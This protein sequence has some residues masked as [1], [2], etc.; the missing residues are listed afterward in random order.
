M[1]CGN[2]KTAVGHVNLHAV[3]ARQAEPAS[4]L[5]RRHL[6]HAS[7]PKMWCGA[8]RDRAPA[9]GMLQRVVQKI[10]RGLLHFL[11]VKLE[12]R[13]GRIESRVELHA[14]PLKGLR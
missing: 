7:L 6:G 12:I 13:Y 10:C 11:I 4:F 8:K 9:R 3:R 2:S 1:F 14:L 5:Y